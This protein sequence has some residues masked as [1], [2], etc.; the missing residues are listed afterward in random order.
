[1]KVYSPG[2]LLLLLSIKEIVCRPTHLPKAIHLPLEFVKRSSIDKRSES[3]QSDILNDADVS[4]LAIKLHIGTPAQSF[5]LLFDTGS[6]D[7]WVPSA[8]CSPLDGC[9]EFLHTYNASNSTSFQPTNDA[10]N[11][12][13][14]TG[15]ASGSYFTDV[16]SLGDPYV[17]QNQTLAMV[18]RSTGMI[19]NQKK[20]YSM[21]LDGIFGAGLPGGTVRHLN[22][23]NRYSPIPVSLYNA[24]LIP[25][26]VFS[27][28]IGA[29][30]TG[31]VVFG[32]TIA[33]PNFVYS[34]LVSGSRWS[35]YSLGFELQ[36]LNSTKTFKFNQKTP[37]AIDTG[38]N[39][40][41]LPTPLAK[42]LAHTIAPGHVKYSAGLFEVNCS[43]TQSTRHFKAFFPDSQGKHLHLSLP[44]A[45]LVA[46]RESDGICFFLFTPSDTHIIFGNMFLRH[47]V[48]VFDFGITP[49]IGFAPF[50]NQTSLEE[51]MTV[52]TH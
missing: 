46:K 7:T 24:G 30:N 15:S 1:M 35:V 13:Y 31:K 26:P 33:S 52:D 6:A 41:Y 29:S 22:G 50:V 39:F 47:F 32:D 23:G 9:P 28:A 19:S 20:E 27:F 8:N 45:K 40:L 36:G 17:I 34:P 14:Y 49:Q 25:K 5:S 44:V 37:A 16:V 10:M 12:T 21:L 43:Y 4:E 48:T 2:C 3:L 18:N 51:T 42:E 11:I 38:S